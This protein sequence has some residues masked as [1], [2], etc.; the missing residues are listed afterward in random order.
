MEASSRDPYLIESVAHAAEV[1]K[2][3]SSPNEVLRLRDLVVRT[4]YKKG[5]VFRLLHTL[6]RSGLVEKVGKNQYR[7][8]LH[9]HRRRKFKLGYASMGTDSPFCSDVMQGLKW[10]ADRVETVEL[11]ILDNRYRSKVAERNA[12]IFVRE[13]V[14]LVMEFQIDEI[15]APIIS[16]TYRK[17]GIPMIAIEIPHP[18][19]T[20]FGANNYEAG[21]IGGRALGRWAKQHWDGQVDELIFMELPRAG[22]VP[23]ARLTGMLVGVRETLPHLGSC[24]VVY[25]DGDGRFEP[26]WKAVRTHLQHSISRHT[27]IGGINDPSAIGALRAFEEAGRLD[28]CAGMGQNASPEARQEL[29]RGSRLVGSVAY[30]PEKYGAG[31]I[32]LALDI[33]SV[34]ATPL[35]VFV[36]HRL[37]TAKNVDQLY[38]NDNLLTS[39]EMGSGM[40][41][42]T[43][44]A[45]RS[46]TGSARPG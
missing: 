39:I 26:S 12:D 17:A 19:A 2:A 27:L 24:P 1:L 44:W 45:A 22:V 25:L 23:R 3:F 38:P 37:L 10:E 6:E 15:M 46:P 4:Q 9:Q 31:L 8:A 5:S 11:L 7:S 14:D 30:F 33:L 18:G 16:A 20:Y 40:T 43:G 29:R 21:L 34:K 32:R 28:G 36:E 13:Q 42:R 35:A 41:A